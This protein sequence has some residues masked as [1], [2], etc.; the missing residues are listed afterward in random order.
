MAGQARDQSAQQ[1]GGQMRPLSIRDLLRVNV[2]LFVLLLLPAFAEPSHAETWPQRTVRFILPLAT[3]TSVDVVARLFA[4]KLST[5]WGQPVV[6]ENRSGGDGVVAITAFLNAQ[7]DHT[8]LFTP[9]SSFAAYPYVHPDE[10]LPY[11]QRDF[12]PIARVSNTVVVI[13]VPASRNINS[14][15]QLVDLAKAN[16]GKLNWS[17]ATGVQDFLF[18]GFEKSGGVKWTKVPYRDTVQALNDLADG[19]I[20]A[21]AG[22]YIIT[23]AQVQAGRV[24][25]LAVMNHERA[26]MLPDVPTVAEAGYPTL[27]YDGLVGLFGIRSMSG[28]LR[29][30]IAADVEAVADKTMAEKIAVGGTVM[31]P[32]KGTQFAAS[33][34]EQRAT[35]AA[36]AGD[37]GIKPA[38]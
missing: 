23:R 34:E 17:T 31:S 9:V 26:P 6:V 30:R 36:I 38:Q 11:N 16:P 25:L 29:D 22:A 12:V 3:S 20:D 8:L 5:R 18:E 10:R 35:V 7:D 37:L 15:K 32:G 13:A 4:E 27:Q 1:K 2:A 28:E 33:I 14:M 19:R 21:Y 24:K